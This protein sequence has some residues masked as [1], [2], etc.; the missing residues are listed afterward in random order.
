M[1][2]FL[3]EYGMFLAKAITVIVT[4]ML[5]LIGLLAIGGRGKRDHAHGEI[6]LT[7]I[8][9]NFEEMKDAIE[10]VVIDPEVYKQQIKALHKKE[11]KEAKEKKKQAKADAKQAKLALKQAEKNPATSGDDTSTEAVN[12]DAVNDQQDSE[13]PTDEHEERKRVFVLDF[14][15]DIRASEV[16]LLREE[17]SAVLA[18]AS[19][20]DEVVLR[21]DSA[22]GMVHSYGLAASQLE[23]IKSAKIKLTICVDEVAASGG[24]M[25]ACL[26]DK[27]IAAPFSILGSIGVVAQLPNFHRVLK[28]HGVDYE[29]FTAGEYKRTVT[30]FGE[31]TEKGKEKFIEEIQDTHLLFKEFVA[32]ARP[33]VDID[34]VATGEVWF[35][36]RALEQNLVD[37]LNTSDDFLMKICQSADVYQVRYE[38][39]KSFG[40]RISEMTVKTTTK[41]VANTLEKMTSSMNFMR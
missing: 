7:S 22:G 36:R 29:T 9:D 14:N 27:L 30:M 5:I 8:N 13:Q 18:F 21:L 26:A 31:N 12:S 24:Y 20:S 25:M 34:K 38:I 16:D 28:K 17:I 2:D 15:G 33:N 10:S 40:E 3:Y 23:R 41:V 37:E 4:I 11:K 1:V 19:P 35:G 32:Q 6:T 39:K